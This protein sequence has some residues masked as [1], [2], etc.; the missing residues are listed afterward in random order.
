MTAITL[1]IPEEIRKKFWVWEVISYENLIIKTI[2]KEYISPDL[3][4]TEYSQMKENHKE[5]YD[6]LE[7]ISKQDLLNI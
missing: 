3:D 5:E 7:N 2:W 6:R 1:E 4:F